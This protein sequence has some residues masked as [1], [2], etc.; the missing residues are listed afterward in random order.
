MADAMGFM[1]GVEA[2]EAGEGAAAAA[3][4]VG[5]DTSAVA[6]EDP[7]GGGDAVN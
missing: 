1:D 5:E 7:V 4:D 2:E 3:T 6:E